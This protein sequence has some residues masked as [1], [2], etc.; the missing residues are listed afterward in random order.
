MR[1]Q[2]I[3]TYNNMYAIILKNKTVYNSIDK[4][5]FKKRDS[6]KKILDEINNLI[7]IVHFP[8]YFYLS[9]NRFKSSG[10]SK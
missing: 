8:E 10:K 1:N 5:T 3:K 7:G 6:N 4:I 9:K 2:L